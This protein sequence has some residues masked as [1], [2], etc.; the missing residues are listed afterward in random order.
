MMKTFFME[1]DDLIA[2]TKNKGEDEENKESCMASPVA[3]NDDHI[4]AYLG[5]AA[6]KGRR[7]IAEE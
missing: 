4:I 5:S 3:I 6:A 1:W 7:S 2:D